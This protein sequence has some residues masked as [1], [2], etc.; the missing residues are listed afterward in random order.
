[1]IDT[2]FNS[3][4]GLKLTDRQVV[5]EIVRF[6]QAD[7]ER[8][9]KVTIGTDSKLYGKTN[10]DFVTA[11][12]VHRVGNGGRYFW[13]RAELGNFHTLRDRILQEV[14]FSLDVTKEILVALK[15]ASAPNFD[16][17]IHVDIG[18]NGETKVMI[19]ELTA[20]IRAN[21]FEV[22]TKPESYSASWVAD[23]HV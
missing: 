1:M 10:A 8:R 13:R 23:R 2:H 17:E 15:E 7:P 5:S 14:M 19:Q 16:F 9:Y 11:V 20:M 12:V 22:K 18:E 6:M 4:L 3:S 21:S